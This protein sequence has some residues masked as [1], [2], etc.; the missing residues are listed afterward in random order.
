[1][2]T[3]AGA[4]ARDLADAACAIRGGCGSTTPT[5]DLWIGD[6]GQGAWEEIDVIRAGTG[7]QNL[8]WNTME[9]THCFATEPMRDQTGLTLPV[10]E[11]GHDAGLLG[12][13]AASSP[14]DGACRRSR[15]ATC[16]ATTARARI[17][18][19]DPTSRQPRRTRP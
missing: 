12:R 10:A 3:T 11:Y 7:G 17:W 8:G 6:V 2:P 14:A 13:R 15:T 5:G 18:S 4:T 9:G 19:L 1:M 16:S